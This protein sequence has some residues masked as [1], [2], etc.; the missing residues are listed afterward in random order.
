MA[1]RREIQAKK[2]GKAVHGILVE[3][4]SNCLIKFS[5]CCTPVPGDDI[6]GFIT[7]GQGVSIHRRDCANCQQLLTQPDND[8]RWV[9]VSWASVINDSYVTT[10]TIAAKDRSGLVMDIATVLNSVNAK[11]R[12]MSAHE[13]AGIG[14]VSVSLEV[15]NAGELKYI[16]GRLSSIPGVSTVSRNRK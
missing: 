12:S 6:A 7:R 2:E 3:G 10:I 5:R 1:E 13:N 11:V 14:L 16:M 15:K 9:E 8:G 4:L